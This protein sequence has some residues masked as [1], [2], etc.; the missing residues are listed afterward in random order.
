MP[1]KYNNNKVIR[2]KSKCGNCMAS[3]SLFLEKESKSEG[4][5]IF[6][7]FLVY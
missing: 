3:K 5:N 4:N 6:S 7:N 2:Q 1:P